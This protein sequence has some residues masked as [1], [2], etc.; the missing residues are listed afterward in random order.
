MYIINKQ[1]GASKYMN[2]KMDELG[3]IIIPADIR[4]MLNLVPGQEMSFGVDLKRKCITLI[5]QG[6]YCRICCSG[7]NLRHVHGRAICEKCLAAA[8]AEQ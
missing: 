5:P 4:D 8:M 3:R 1:K 2:R 7:E 6:E